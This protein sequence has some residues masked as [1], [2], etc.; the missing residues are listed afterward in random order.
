ME[1][2][3][4]LNKLTCYT[5][6][7]YGEPKNECDLQTVRL[8]ENGQNS[9]DPSALYLTD[10]SFLPSETQSG[11]FVIFC[12][13]TPIDFSK[14][15]QSTFTLVF[16]DHIASYQHFFNTLQA[17]LTE[18]QQITAGMHI[19]VNA[20]ISEKGLQYLVDTAAKIFCNPLYVIDLQHKYLAISSG[21]FPN[22][23]F[24]QMENKA[25]YIS[26]EGLKFIRKNKIDE[27]VRKNNT[28][29]YFVNPLIGQGMLIDV[30]QIQ[31]IE[32]GHIMLQEA[33]HA[34]NEFDSDLFHR[35]SKLV[36]ME[37]QKDT[38]FANNK[39]VMY[40]YFLA[41]LLKNPNVN[42]SLVKKRLEALGY[43]LKEDLYIIVIP[44]ISYH[45]TELRLEVIIQHIRTIFVGC[46]Y[47]IYEDTI[48]F[49]ISRNKYQGL[50]PFELEQFTS[51]LTANQLKA[52]ISN[53]FNHLEDAHRFYKQAVD[54]VKLGLQLKDDSPIFYYRDYYIYQMLKIYE[55]TDKEIRFLIHPGLMQLYQYDQEKRTEF[56]YTLKE[57]LIHP[58]QPSVVADHLHIHKNTLLYRMGKIKEITHCEFNEGEDFMSFG[59]SFKIMEYLHMI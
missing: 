51:F 56:M 16:F 47:V 11:H 44:S 36:S 48:V 41:D 58:G 57:Y 13:G 23:D 26:E 9:F 34:F 27:K 42:T 1:L 29:Y 5:F 12:Y 49:L 38:V 50:Q 32:V 7:Q 28:P 22:N 4:L 53:F 10:T 30:I 3:T 21:I 31:G 8:Y 55:K 17:H 25:G 37:L 6:K 54:S 43:K 20:L 59:L 39:G 24:F 33:E 15:E 2:K 40:S 18:V 14:Y 45:T 52:G 46:I 35:F 19:M